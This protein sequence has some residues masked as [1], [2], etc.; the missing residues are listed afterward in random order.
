VA[1]GVEEGAKTGFAW[2]LGTSIPLTHSIFGLIEGVW[3]AARGGRGFAAGLLSL[4]SHTCF[5]LAAGWLYRLTASVL[6]AVA[7][8]CLLHMIWNG[9]ILN[10]SRKP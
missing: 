7:G 4:V 6:L 1:P 2:L 5:G 10:L 3:D 9:L 8:S